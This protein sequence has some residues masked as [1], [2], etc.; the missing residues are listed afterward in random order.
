M[1]SHQVFGPTR[2]AKCPCG[3]GLRLKHCCGS[4]TTDRD[5]PR[6]IH[7]VPNII[8]EELCVKLTTYLSTRDGENLKI[9]D[10]SNTTSENIS[11][12]FNN[13]R[14][15]EKVN[16]GGEQELFNNIIKAALLEVVEPRLEIKIEWYEKPQVLRYRTGGIYQAHADSD[17]FD[18]SKS[19]WF[20][21][22]DR[23]ISILLYLND[24]FTGGTLSFPNFR[25][26]LQPKA[27]MLVFFPSDK[28]YIHSADRV[29]SGVRYALVSWASV[30]GII[31]VRNQPPVDSLILHD[32]LTHIFTPP[33]GHDLI[34]LLEG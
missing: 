32:D 9:V 13:G 11:R 1:L 31:K 26:V 21:I 28:R 29:L 18:K 7:I 24:G 16:L 10:I 30:R 4:I 19:T 3:S 20:K 17:Y 27:G 34:N 5:A 2:T 33:P 22:L 15:A 23:D 14:I 8:E 6:E 12:S 25:Y